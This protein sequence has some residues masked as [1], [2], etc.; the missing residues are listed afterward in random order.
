MYTL[1]CCLLH[2]SPVSNREA[3]PEAAG[4]LSGE[5]QE[6]RWGAP[7]EQNREQFLETP[8]AK[9]AKVVEDFVGNFLNSFTLTGA[10]VGNLEKYDD[11]LTLDYKFVVQELRKDGWQFAHRPAARG[12]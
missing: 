10:S 2:Q 3:R 6:V 7:A 9:R 1:P 11:N 4:N 12:R 5:V 8:P